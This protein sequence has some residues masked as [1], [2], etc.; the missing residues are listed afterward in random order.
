MCIHSSAAVFADGR[1][2]CTQIYVEVTVDEA[3][4]KLVACTS[5]EM[6]SQRMIQVGSLFGWRCWI[7]YADARDMSSQRR[8]D[9]HGDTCYSDTRTVRSKILRTPAQSGRLR[10]GTS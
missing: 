8:I 3:R 9:Y 5:C 10:Y 6:R 1:P 7:S 4:L 2:L